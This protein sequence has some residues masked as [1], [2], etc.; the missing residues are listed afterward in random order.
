MDDM[1]ERS[2]LSGLF[3]EIGAEAPGGLRT[4]APAIGAAQGHPT[5]D[6]SADFVL[7]GVV[8]LFAWFFGGLDG[9]LNV[10]ITFVIV[11]FILSCLDKVINRKFNFQDF[12]FRIG[13]KITIFLL[14]GVCHVLDKYLLGDTSAIRT[15]VTIFYTINE[16]T[17]MLKHA[18][19]LGVQVPDFL[20]NRIKEIQK[21]LLGKKEEEEK[22]PEQQIIDDFFDIRDYINVDEIEKIEKSELDKDFIESLTGFYPDDWS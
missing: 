17:S 4:A 22:K 6:E 15:G 21:Q 7:G 16:F 13:K 19:N 2:V 5:V 20:M 18:H 12:I 10:L 3:H 9:Y 14:V 8:G 11:N 1:G